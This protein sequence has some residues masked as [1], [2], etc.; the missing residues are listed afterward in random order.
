VTIV[1]GIMAILLLA[2]VVFLKK[3]MTDMFAIEAEL[4]KE[5]REIKG[6]LIKIHEKQL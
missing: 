6:C 3:F 4:I 2:T 1:L 5:L